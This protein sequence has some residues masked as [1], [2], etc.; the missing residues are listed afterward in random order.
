[1]RTR[2][3]NNVVQPVKLFDGVVRYDITKRAFAAEPVSHHD[4]I[5]VPAWKDAMDVEFAALCLNNTWRLVEPPKGHHIV[6]CKW[7]Y[8]LKQKPDGT[9]G[10]YKARLVAKGFT[11]RAGIDYTDTFSPVVKPTTVKLILSI[12]VSRNWVLRHVHVQNAFLHG[13]IQEEVYMSQPPGYVDPHRPH[14]VCRLQKSLYG[15]KQAPRA[16]YSKLSVKLQSLGFTP[17]KADTSLFIFLD[18]R[19]TIYML[20]YVDDII[21]AGSCH[22][23]VER[24]LKKL[25][26]SFAVKDLGNCHT[27]LE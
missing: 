7:V 9:I 17:S 11:Q 6:G 18:T 14:H 27:F 13:D 12:A 1:M 21:V 2:L 20:I 19:V 16:W 4:A 8:K 23:A 5:G 10:R 24:L 15:L 25:R 22:L 26:D 3:R